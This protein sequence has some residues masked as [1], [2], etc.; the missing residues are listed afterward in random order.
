M[1]GRATFT[2]AA[3]ARILYHLLLL[4]INS[5]LFP[6]SLFFGL[7]GRAGDQR[8]AAFFASH[9]LSIPMPST[10]FSG[11]ARSPSFARS[12]AAGRGGEVSSINQP[13]TAPNEQVCPGGLILPPMVASL[14]SPNSRSLAPARQVGNRPTRRRARTQLIPSRLRPPGLGRDVSPPLC[15]FRQSAIA[16]PSNN[17]PVQFVP[18][19][20]FSFVLLFFFTL[21]LFPSFGGS[22]TFPTRPSGSKDRATRRELE[23][24]KGPDYFSNR[25]NTQVHLRNIHLLDPDTA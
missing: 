3:V 23:C 8:W 18:S 25:L 14:S 7:G 5:S 16:F 2:P 19:P 24:I 13:S 15:F 11:G 12:S 10:E 21:S 17:P 1:E 6:P 22:S 9:P 20:L 4:S